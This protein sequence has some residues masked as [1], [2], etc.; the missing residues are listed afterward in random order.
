[1]TTKNRN[2][3]LSSALERFRNLQ[4]SVTDNEA[5]ILR[6]KEC[7]EDERARIVRSVNRRLRTVM[8]AHNSD[9]TGRKG[10]RLP[11]HPFEKHGRLDKGLRSLDELKVVSV[12]LDADHRIRIDLTAVLKRPIFFVEAHQIYEGVRKAL[13]SRVAEMLSR[14][15]GDISTDIFLIYHPSGSGLVGNYESGYY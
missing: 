15:P 12:R 7:L 14:M 2:A 6:F 13:R 9:E 11:R 8:S 3:V 4:E 10:R 1:M 5:E